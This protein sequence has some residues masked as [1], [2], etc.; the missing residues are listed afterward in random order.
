[1]QGTTDI[2]LRKIGQQQKKST[3]GQIKTNKEASLMN[4]TAKDSTQ[5]NGKCSNV[6]FGY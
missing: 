5:T 2:L 3:L 4:D 1:L 6:T